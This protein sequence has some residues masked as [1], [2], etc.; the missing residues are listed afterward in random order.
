MVK[1]FEFWWPRETPS[2]WYPEIWSYFIFNLYLS[3]PKILSVWR[4][5][6]KNLNLG[7]TAWGDTPIFVRF[8]LF[9]ISSHSENL[10]HPALMVKKFKI[11]A[12]QLEGNPHFD[13]LKFCQ[14]LS[15]L[16]I[17]LP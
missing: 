11:L 4:E 5:W 8:S 17:C 9:L 12:A 15:F 13:T 7:G 1:N 16:H 10:I 3:I 6:L 14:L 2:F